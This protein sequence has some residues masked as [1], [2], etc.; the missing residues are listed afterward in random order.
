MSQRAYDKVWALL[1]KNPGASET[2]N[3]GFTYTSK[4]VKVLLEKVHNRFK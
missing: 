4:E 3:I 2:L 1:V